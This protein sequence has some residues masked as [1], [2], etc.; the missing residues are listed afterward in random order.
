MHKDS[1]I[2][3]AGTAADQANCLAAFPFIPLEDRLPRNLWESARLRNCKNSAIENADLAL[4]APFFLVKLSNP[5]LKKNNAEPDQRREN[6]RLTIIA[7]T[8]FFVLAACD[9]SAKDGGA[10]HVDAHDALSA[11]TQEF[12]KEVIEVTEGVHVA[13]GFGLANSIMIEGD[14]GV[15]IIDTMESRS[16]AEA[17]KAEFQKIS[18]KPIK[19]V[20]ITHNHTDH[21]FGSSVFAPRGSDVP[22][23]AHET[24]EFY[25]DRIINVINDAI[26]KRSM[27]MFGQMLPDGE[28]INAGIGPELKYAP[29]E[30][31]LTR[32]THTFKETMDL[33]IAGVE[34]RLVHAPGETADQLFVY[35]P[36]KRVLMPGD[37][38]YRAFPNLYTIRGTAYRDVMDWAKSLDKMRAL[39]P[40]HLVPSHT[41]PVSDE[42]HVYETLTAY[43]DAIQYVHDQTIRYINNGD[44]PDQIVEKVH[45]PDHLAQNPWLQEFYGTVE[46]SVR[47]IFT[48]YLGWFD[49]NAA[50]LHKLPAQERANRIAKAFEGT[51]GL[52]AAAQSALDAGDHLWAAELAHELLQLN[53]QDSAASAIKASAYRALAAKHVS[54]N[55]RN[56]YLSQAR[57][58]DGTLEVGSNKRDTIPDEFIADLPIRNLMYAM[59]VRLKA[60]ETLDMQRTVVF[61]FADV[62]ESYTFFVRNGIVEVQPVATEEADL[63]IST[64]TDTWKQIVFQKR[65]PPAAYGSGDLKVEG[66][67]IKVVSFLNL[68]ER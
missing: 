36:E 29:E 19:G 43:R 61:H 57:E 15:I 66:G 62:G 39:R 8:S 58:A 50:T 7:L 55:G 21:I 31:A 45:L 24:T 6:M 40:E 65:G 59:P 14:D 47:S 11:H 68:F 51:D 32:P 17:V 54:A 48:G 34:I 52:G 37:N 44:T 20:I 9:D 10:V 13:V 33:E 42:E 3:V 38:F 1:P 60:E 25:I 4:Q 67:V 12:R 53:P 23:Y 49:G 28:L 26:F 22:V 63:T 2:T 41:R 46:W 27:R 35:L 30:M 56:Y 16:E 18:T 5:R 64:T